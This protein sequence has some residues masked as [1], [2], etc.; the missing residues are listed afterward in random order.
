MGKSGLL[1][2]QTD[3]GHIVGGTASAAGLGHEDSELVGVILTR[4]DSIHDLSDGD[5]G[6]IAGVVVDKLEAHIHRAAVIAVSRTML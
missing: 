3:K 5:E 6:R 1:Q 4:E 2:R